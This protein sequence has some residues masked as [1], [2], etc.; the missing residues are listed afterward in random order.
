FLI[1]VPVT[2]SA[3][4]LPPLTTVALGLVAVVSTVFL[5]LS[6]MPLPW[7]HSGDFE[8]PLLYSV[9]TLGSLVSGMTFLALY[10]WRLASESLQM[11]DALAATE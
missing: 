11:S 9:G 2:V 10:A 3:S 8:L 1:V 6:H 7:T 4:T 5:T